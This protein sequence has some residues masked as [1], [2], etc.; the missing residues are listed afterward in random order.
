MILIK[1]LKHELATIVFVAPGIRTFQRAVE[2]KTIMYFDEKMNNQT[3]RSY[4]VHIRNRFLK[5]R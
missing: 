2:E 3:N 1:R 5:S 4:T